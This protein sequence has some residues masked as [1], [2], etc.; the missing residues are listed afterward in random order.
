MVAVL[1]NRYRIKQK[2][3]EGGMGSVWLAVDE[4]L[5]N[6]KVAIKVLP[7]DLLKNVGAV[8]RLKKEAQIS[9]QLSHPN[10]SSI[11]GFEIHNGEFAYIIMDYVDGE[12][13]AD[14]LS[15][16]GTLSD[17][18]TFAIFAPLV[19]GVNYAHSKNIIH[20]DIKA[21]NIMIDKDGTP[22]LLD[23]GISDETRLASGYNTE[24]S[25]T[26]LYMSPE[27]LRGEAPHVSHD[28]Y[29]LGA[30]AYEC[31]T[32]HPPFYKGDVVNDILTK[33]A[34]KL[35]CT[36]TFCTRIGFA[37]GK[38]LTLRP[39]DALQIANAE[40]RN[41]SFLMFLLGK[42]EDIL[43]QRIL[44]NVMAMQRLKAVGIECLKKL[45]ENNTAKLRLPYLVSQKHVEFTVTRDDVRAIYW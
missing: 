3:G 14:Y 16:K 27:Q 45:E 10:L 42:I 13:L 20:R 31:L 39:K 33:P 25:G 40:L 23:F 35:N 44:N 37:I 9:I 18:E 32:G 19:S 29:S 21:A 12:T 15:R 8:L 17:F 2:L 7:T 5:D 24:L 41:M 26:L 28:V 4:L 1:N 36:C 34:P 11:R 38:N 43:N 30:T 6:R 22:V